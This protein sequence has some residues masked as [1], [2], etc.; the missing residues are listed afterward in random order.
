MLTSMQCFSCLPVSRSIA[1]HYIDKQNNLYNV[2][3]WCH[4]TIKYNDTPDL[5][6]QHNNFKPLPCMLKCV[7]YHT[8]GEI[9]F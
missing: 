1:H 2:R 3:S 9:L 5:L 4:S 7:K 6:K 8:I